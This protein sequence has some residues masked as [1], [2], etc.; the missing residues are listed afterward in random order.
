M[1]NGKVKYEPCAPSEANGTSMKFMDLSGD[2]L[3]LPEVD[4][5]KKKIIKKIIFALG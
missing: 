5:V 2:V 4:I 3:K 1:V